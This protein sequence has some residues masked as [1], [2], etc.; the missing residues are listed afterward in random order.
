MKA[1]YRLFKRGETYYIEDGE[2]RKQK[3]LHTS[4][5]IEAERMLAAKNELANK[6]QLALAVGQ[7]YI[8][9]M[10]PEMLDRK[11]CD[12]M[13]IMVQRGGAATQDRTKRAFNHRAFDLIRNKIIIETT[14]M[15]FLAVL[16][17]G[18]KATN[19]F[20]KLLQTMVINLG[21]LV[22]RIILSKSCWPKINRLKKRAVTWEEHCK[23]VA[24]E[25]NVQRRHYYEILWETGASQMDAAKLSAADID[26][27]L[28]ILVYHRNKTGRQASISIGAR[29]RSILKQLPQEGLLFPKISKMNSTAR[30]AEFNRRCKTVGIQGISLH[31][32]RYAWAERAYAVGYPQRFAQA[33]LGHDSP[34]IHH[35]YAKQAKVVCPALEGYTVRAALMN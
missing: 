33:A 24:V 34:A 2:T 1:N 21:W 10:N 9:A 15:D 35:A 20:L 22:G 31:S 13:S 18:K 4:D 14:A 19:H 30:A 3:S 5:R 32:Y 26:W 6:G 7:I 28:N 17:A 29:F 23:I 8:S 27:Q 11:W 16:S 12:A 25:K